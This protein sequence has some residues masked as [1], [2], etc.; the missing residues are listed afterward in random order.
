MAFSCHSSV[1][2]EPQLCR[3]SSACPKLQSF[4]PV[5]NL[6]DPGGA[7]V[8]AFIFTSIVS[9]LHYTEPQLTLTSTVIAWGKK[10]NKNGITT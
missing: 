3:T 7:V 9:P 2:Y 5:K 8:M 4:D 10:Q 6:T 1:L